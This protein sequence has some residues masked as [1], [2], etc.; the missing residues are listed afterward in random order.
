MS[1]MNDNAFSGISGD[2]NPYGSAGNPPRTDGGDESADADSAGSNTGT[3]SLVDLFND[4]L[5][6][7]R[8][9]AGAVSS[10]IGINDDI[11]EDDGLLQSA[12]DDEDDDDKL[13]QYAGS[14]GGDLF[15]SADDDDDGGDLFQSAAG[16]DELFQPE[17]DGGAI[18]PDFQAAESSVALPGFKRDSARKTIVRRTTAVFRFLLKLFKRL[19]ILSLILA[20][21]AA[22]YY[23]YRIY[24]PGAVADKEY[25]LIEAVYA[26]LYTSVSATGKITAADETAIYLETSQKVEKVNVKEGDRVY[27]GQ[28]LITYDIAPELKSLDQKRQIAYINQLNAELG[29]QRIALPA[30][31]NELLSYTADVNGARKSIQDSESSI[32]SINIRINQQQIRVEDAENLAGKNGALYEQGFLTKEEYD[33]S[34]SS[35]KSANES[36]NDLV[37]S[38]GSEQQNLEYRRTQLTN[39]EQKLAN[40]KNKLGDEASRLMYEQQLN[41]AE[42]SRIEIEQIDDDIKKLVEYT[43]SPINGNVDSIGVTDGATATRNNPVIKLSDLSSLVVKADVSQYDAPKLVIGQRVEILAAGLPDKRYNGVVTKI[44]AASVEKESGSEKEVV[45]P[46]EITLNDVDR[47]VKAGYSVDIEVI[48]EEYANRLSVPSQVVFDDGDGQYVYLLTL[49]DAAGDGA[50]DASGDAKGFSG[51]DGPD[52]GLY[53][54]D[55][56]SSIEDINGAIAYVKTLFGMTLEKLDGLFPERVSEA[57]VPVKHPVET[58]FYGDN[59]VE[60][61]A[62]LAPDEVVVLNP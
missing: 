59:G 42:L 30:A 19:V 9:G 31:G 58:G 15:Q 17:A 57:P 5:T 27:A 39:A 56:F 34:V 60:I 14:D 11:N 23:Y 49:P 55:G 38:L 40:V 24:L 33:L 51:D 52:I 41:I 4:A 47:Q 35:L 36:L 22:I 25:M 2:D 21:A 1:E 28:V 8:S 7:K 6:R 54:V 44:A 61:I 45:V 29:A 12:D 26:D 13:F 32:E 50:D 37:L 46:V 48:V 43:S 20:A 62:G 18:S 53:I 3:L 16:D 10:G